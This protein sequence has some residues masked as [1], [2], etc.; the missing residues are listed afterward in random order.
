[1][2]TILKFPKLKELI[3]EAQ[4]YPKGAKLLTHHPTCLKVIL[5]VKNLSYDVAQTLADSRL[6]T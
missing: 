4:L 6:A 3:L 1:M 5:R 2:K